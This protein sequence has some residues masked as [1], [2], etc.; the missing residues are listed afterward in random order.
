MDAF[1]ELLDEDLVAMADGQGGS[2][3]AT[4]PVP[5]EPEEASRLA[6]YDARPR[7]RVAGDAERIGQSAPARIARGTPGIE[8]E[9]AEEEPDAPRL[10]LHQAPGRL[11][12]TWAAPAAAFGCGLLAFALASSLLGGGAPGASGSSARPGR[13]SPPSIAASNAAGPAPSSTR[14][15]TSAIPRSGRAPQRKRPAFTQAPVSRGRASAHPLEPVPVQAA[16]AVVGGEPPTALPIPAPAAPATEAPAGQ[17][18]PPEEGASKTSY[19]PQRA[20][21]ETPGDLGC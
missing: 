2:E 12:G 9:P 11:R 19:W 15:A 13:V 20:G 21:C 7:H 8:R 6:A 17:A 5:P 14:H 10:R 4:E 1:S 3:S 18:P 16:G